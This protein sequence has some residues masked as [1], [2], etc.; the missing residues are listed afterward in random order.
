VIATL[1]MSGRYLPESRDPTSKRV[2][3][4]GQALAILTLATL[5]IALV[6]GRTLGVAST[7]ALGTVVAAGAVGFIWTQRRGSQPTIPPQFFANGRLLVA[8]FATFAMTFGTYGMLLNSLA[9]QQLRGASAL[10]TAVE[11]L[12]MPLMYLAL[13]PVVNA[14]ARRTGPRL[15]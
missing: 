12:P 9:F 1:L 15:R 13:I 8:L 14:V 4:A 10:A 5:T 7:A 6:E 2:D 11:F 3:L